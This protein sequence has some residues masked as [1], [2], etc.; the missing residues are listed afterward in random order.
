MVT[1]PCI[2]VPGPQQI[3][4][5]L[6][7]EGVINPVDLPSVWNAQALLTP[8]GGQAASPVDPGDQLVVG[9]I[10]YDASGSGIRFMKVGLYLLESLQYYDFMFTTSGAQNQWWWLISNPADPNGP[11]T[12]AFGPFSTGAKVPPVDF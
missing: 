11:P 3:H 6:F 9:N 1:V 12:K 5:K 4:N 10:T 7:P 8:F 2:P